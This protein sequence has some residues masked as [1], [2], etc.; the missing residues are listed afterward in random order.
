MLPLRSEIVFLI[1]KLGGLHPWETVE[2]DDSWGL[3]HD[4]TMAILFS[5]DYNIDPVREIESIQSIHIRQLQLRMP[6]RPKLQ[7]DVKDWLDHT[8]KTED[9]HLNIE[10]LQLRLFL[11]PSHHLSYVEMCVMKTNILKIHP[12]G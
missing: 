9:Y 11:M 4:K 1:F 8:C 5:L 12:F 3:S 7:M 2:L 10:R 6:S